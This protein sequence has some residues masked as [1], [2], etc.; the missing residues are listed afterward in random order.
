M[1]VSVLYRQMLIPVFIVISLLF[2]SCSKNELETLTK[3]MEL[4]QAGNNSA[5]YDLLSENTTKH[6]SRTEFDNYCFVFRVID[7]E[8]MKDKNG[9]FEIEYNFYDK[10]FNK[11]SGE[12]HTFYITKNKESVKFED[13]KIVFPHIG[14]LIVREEIEKRNIEKVEKTLKTMLKIDPENREVTET[15]A[16]MGF[17]SVNGL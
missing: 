15:A 9:Y 4:R 17:V 16:K 6:F 1:N 14:F 5:A 13:R 8:I 7:F 12:L 10:K 2:I 3:F 11:E